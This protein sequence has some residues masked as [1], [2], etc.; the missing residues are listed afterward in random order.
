MSF[1]TC[2]CTLAP[3]GCL[4]CQIYNNRFPE[5]DTGSLTLED[6]FWPI[7]NPKTHELVEKPEAKAKRLKQQIK[8]NE[9]YLDRVEVWINHLLETVT[10]TKEEIEK[11]KEDLSKIE[12]TKEAE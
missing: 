12:K 11:D 7:Y 10:K 5:L 1:I 6:Y 8:D 2:H 4:N 9:D 3:E